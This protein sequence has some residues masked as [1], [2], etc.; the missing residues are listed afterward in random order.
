MPIKP[1]VEEI[2]VETLLTLLVR[3]I[4][5]TKQISLIQVQADLQVDLWVDPR[6][7]P[8]A[9]M[10]DILAIQDITT[11]II[12]GETT[13]LTRRL[14]KSHLPKG[15]TKTMQR[16]N[17]IAIAFSSFPT[18]SNKTL[19]KWLLASLLR[20]LPSNEVAISSLKPGST[21]LNRSFN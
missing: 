3:L 4:G 21:M 13:R 2:Q 20:F 14:Q 16:M 12:E 10:V 5:G 9:E 1:Q 15:I 8:L 18:V 7:D 11:V 19:S 17:A 6:V